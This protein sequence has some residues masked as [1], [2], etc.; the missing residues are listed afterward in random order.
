LNLATEKELIITGNTTQRPSGVN[1]EAVMP[2]QF[3]TIPFLT[4][5]R[6]RMQQRAGP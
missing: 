5:L 1:W 3:E 4:S 6:E 2:D